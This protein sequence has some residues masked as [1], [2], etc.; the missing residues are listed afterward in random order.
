MRTAMSFCF[1]LTPGP[2]PEQDRLVLLLLQVFLARTSVGFPEISPAGF[3]GYGTTEAEARVL[4][5][6]QCCH[7]CI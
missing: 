1:S 5:Y 7:V 3:T 4:L 6:A 2:S